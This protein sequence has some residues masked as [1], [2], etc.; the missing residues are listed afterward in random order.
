MRYQNDD[1]ACKRQNYHSSDS[2][3]ERRTWF[4]AGEI[5][6]CHNTS[7]PNRQKDINTTQN[8]KKKEKIIKNK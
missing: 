4:M 1:K 3:N 2:I 7:S 8:E 6:S 5:S